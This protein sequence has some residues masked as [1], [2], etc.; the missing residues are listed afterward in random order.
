MHG[1]QTI[2]VHMERMQLTSDEAKSRGLSLALHTDLNT[3]V[4]EQKDADAKGRE[5]Q[6][7]LVLVP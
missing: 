5:G 4:R 7:T 1:H 3:E 2:Y 6:S